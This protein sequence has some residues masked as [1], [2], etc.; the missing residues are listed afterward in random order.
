MFSVGFVAWY[1]SEKLLSWK[2]C[3]WKFDKPRF[4]T[5]PFTIQLFLFWNRNFF[6]QLNIVHCNLFCAWNINCLCLGLKMISAHL[7]AQ[8]LLSWIWSPLFHA[9]QCCTQHSM[10][11]SKHQGVTEWVVCFLNPHLRKQ[12]FSLKKLQKKPSTVPRLKQKFSCDEVPLQTS[13]KPL[14]KSAQDHQQLW[15]C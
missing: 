7:I 9:L 3:T 14:K 15:V 6:L 12:T 13:A 8:Q 11:S 5:A 10:A 1:F 4:H 2:S